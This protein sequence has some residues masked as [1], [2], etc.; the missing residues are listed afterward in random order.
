MKLVLS[1]DSVAIT[2]ETFL[3]KT[4]GEWDQH[5]LLIGSQRR[6]MEFLE[7]ISTI[8]YQYDTIGL[9]N[10]SWETWYYFLMRHETEI[11]KALHGE[12]SVL[13]V[14]DS[15]ARCCGCTAVL[16]EICRDMRVPFHLLA[17]A[18]FP[19]EGRNRRKAVEQ[20]IVSA[21]RDC[22]SVAVSHADEILKKSTD[23]T[24]M[25]EAFELLEDQLISLMKKILPQILFLP[26]CC[27][28]FYNQE[29]E[30]YEMVEDLGSVT[31]KYIDRTYQ[32]YDKIK[33]NI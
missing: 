27:Q 24:T 31:L 9:G 26:S 22:V 14:V 8:V 1:L 30:A 16:E 17:V 18:P 2:W 6:S 33:E 4:A 11:R 7:N 21:S 13:C 25:T 29:N 15:D 28:Y 3:K 10:P 19:F 32:L 5:L 23:S 12:D 20:R